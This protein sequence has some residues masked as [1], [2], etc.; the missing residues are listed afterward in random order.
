MIGNH[1]IKGWSVTQAVIALSSGE[2]E[3][4]GIVKGCSVGL[5]MRE[6]LL[7]LGIEVKLSVLTDASAAKETPAKCGTSRSTSCGSRKR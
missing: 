4:Y 7:D 6:L 1:L 5:G 2:A 3:Y